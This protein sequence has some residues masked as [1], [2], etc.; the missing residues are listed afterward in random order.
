VSSGS[1]EGD[2]QTLTI[3][4]PENKT[5]NRLFLLNHNFNKYNV[6]YGL[7]PTNFANITS[8]N[9]TLKNN[10]ITFSQDLDN[11]IWTKGGSSITTNAVAAPD[12]SLTADNLIENSANSTH[13]CAQT[14][15]SITSGAQYTG[16]AY[17]K[18]AGRGYITLRMQA[19]S[20]FDTAINLATGLITGTTAGATSRVEDVGGGW[21]R[22]SLTVT[23]SATGTA[24]FS[25]RLNNGATATYLG[26][27]V[28]GVSIWGAQMVVGTQ[29][30][31]YSSRLSALMSE[32]NYNYNSSYYEFDSV[33]T[34]QI[35]ISCSN[36]Q[37]SVTFLQKYL[38]SL[39]IC[40]EIGEFSIDGLALPNANH[41]ANNR[42]ARN[43]NNKALV[44]RGTDTFS[45]SLNSQM[46]STQADLELY[47]ELYDRNEDFLVWLC[48]ARVGSPY[49]RLEAR[50]YRL[51]DLY[52][53]R[54][55]SN[56][57]TNYYKGLF[58][59]GVGAA[60]NLIEVEG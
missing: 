10:L 12:G 7:S 13:T 50:G 42:I 27:G 15:I 22:V 31:T 52:R 35:N 5:F 47:N 54:N 33:T 2:T 28:S 38:A 18:N 59:S 60:L 34:N 21:Y 32:L 46:V 49:F 43:V 6:T 8:I 16:S 9:S 19:T 26:D 1:S 36:V 44:Q 30:L 25:F 48:G 40:N 55:I 4:L 37:N 23:A 3:T 39:V 45:V 20:I 58:N 11:A 29:A 53:V 17:F 41:D 56:L 14:S 57:D 24:T 51:L